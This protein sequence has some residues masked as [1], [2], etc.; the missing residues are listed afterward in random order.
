VLTSDVD[1]F[2]GTNLLWYHFID[3]YYEVLC[4]EQWNLGLF[5]IVGHAEG[6]HVLIIDDLVQTGGTLIECGKVRWLP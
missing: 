4:I 2:L 5:D 6:R 3:H 1:D